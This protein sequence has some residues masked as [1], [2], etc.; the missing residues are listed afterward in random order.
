MLKSP[1]ETEPPEGGTPVPVAGRESRP[2]AGP[3]PLRSSSAA[4]P[5][6][7]RGAVRVP[8]RRQR[9]VVRGAGRNDLRPGRA[10]GLRQDDQPQDGQPPDRADL[11]RDPARRRRRHGRERDG[12]PA[13]DRL[14]DPAG[15]PVPASHDRQERGCRPGL[16]G[17]A[18]ARQR[19]RTDEL[20]E[21][22]GLD[23]AAIAAGIP[24]SSPAASGSASAW[25]GRWP[26]IRRSC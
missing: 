10:V 26:R 20:L 21:L 2:R 23:P 7:T 1:A 22:V 18:R 6:A 5:S 15:R 8:G 14:R 11:R 16:G 19:A 17:L 3:G 9:P 24:T 13:A 4:S 25:P 12:A